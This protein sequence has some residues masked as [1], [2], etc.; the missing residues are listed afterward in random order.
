MLIADI[1]TRSNTAWSFFAF[2]IV[3]LL[4]AYAK[5]VLRW[6]VKECKKWKLRRARKPIQLSGYVRGRK[7]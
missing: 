7:R 4:Y 3:C 5:P 2:G 1:Y 6:T